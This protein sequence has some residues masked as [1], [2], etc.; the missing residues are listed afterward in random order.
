MK[1]HKWRRRQV[2]KM[3]TADPSRTA[4]SIGAELE[5]S[6]SRVTEILKQEGLWQNPWTFFNCGYCGEKVSILKSSLKQKELRGNTEHF[7]NREH[8]DRHRGAYPYD[9]T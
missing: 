1:K 5:L 8:Y 3:N 7:C 2:V 9:I 6:V 4:T